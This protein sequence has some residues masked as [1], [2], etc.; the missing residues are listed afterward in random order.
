MSELSQLEFSGDDVV[1]ARVTGEIDLSNASDVGEALAGAVPNTALGLVIDLTATSYLDSSGVHLLFDLAERLQR[2]QQQLQVVV[3]E[4]A[5]VRRV[6]RIVE[7]DETV[8]LT[9]TVDEAVAGIR[10]AA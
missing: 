5:P 3:P 1:I 10:G 8:P 7:L 4:G 2:R 9:A 6:L